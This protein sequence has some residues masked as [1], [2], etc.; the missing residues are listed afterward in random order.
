MRLAGA[1]ECCREWPLVSVG[2]NGLGQPGGSLGR[3]ICHASQ[4]T[5]DQD[6][7]C[8]EALVDNGGPIRR[9]GIFG[10]WPKY[11]SP[12]SAD[13]LHRG[14]SL[15]STLGHLREAVGRQCG[16]KRAASLLLRFR[17]KGLWPTRLSRCRVFLSRRLARFP[18]DELYSRGCD[19]ATIWMRTP[20]AI[21]V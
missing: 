16:K 19:G 6:H 1:R 9:L 10:K 14:Q 18:A 15:K 4:A 13:S 11:T 3:T 8:S 2:R 12:Y 21:R 7:A 20:A 5:S 17:R